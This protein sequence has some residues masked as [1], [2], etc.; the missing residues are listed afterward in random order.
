MELETNTPVSDEERALAQAKKVTIEPLHTAVIRDDTPDAVIVAN[1]LREGALANVS[2]DIEQNIPQITAAD[3]ALPA[4][5]QAPL[6]LYLLTGTGFLALAV[7]IFI[8]I[9]TN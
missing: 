8:V 6:K 2:N 3:T 4:P 9:F 5:T 7:V 1:H